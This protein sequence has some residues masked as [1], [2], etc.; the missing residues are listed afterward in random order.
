MTQSTT[1]L[2]IPVTYDP[3]KTTEEEARRIVMDAILKAMPSS[4]PAD[5]VEGEGK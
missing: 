1:Y 2:A 5:D 3:D 4:S